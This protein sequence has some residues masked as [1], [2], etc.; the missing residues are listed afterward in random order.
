MTARSFGYHRGMKRLL[1]FVVCVAC[2]APAG[3]SDAAAPAESACTKIG[4][5]CTFAPGKL[6]MCVE[7]EPATSPATLVC[8][9]QH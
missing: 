7:A 4:A 9:S 8:Q 1:L 5:T 6:G 3:S 2:R